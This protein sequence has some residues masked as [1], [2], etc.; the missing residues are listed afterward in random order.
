YK[1]LRKSDGKWIIVI[2]DKDMS[3]HTIDSTDEDGDAGM[4]D[5]TGFS[6]SLSGEI[7]SEGKKS[8]ESNIGEIN[9]ED[10]RSLVKS[11]EELGEMFPDSTDEDGD[12]GMDDSTGV[13]V[14]LSGEIS[15]EG[16]KS[17]ELNIGEINSEDKRSLV[18]SSE[19]L[20]EMF[21]GV[22]RE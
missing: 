2:L 7:S 4:D 12:A 8:R 22:T 9:S 20:G 6:V 5:S 3:H 21:P 1:G 10:K 18:K 13:S 19:E 15:S 16:K 17:R 14:S 11:S